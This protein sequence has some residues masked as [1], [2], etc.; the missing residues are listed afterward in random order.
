MR[1]L[2]AWVLE[3]QH[4]PAP[5]PRDLSA[6]KINN[7]AAYAAQP[8]EERMAIIDDMIC[9][10]LGDESFVK[11]LEDVDQSWRRIGLGI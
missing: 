9:E 8:R 10:C 2:D 4:L 3:Y 1:R 6:D 11:L 5:K 7:L